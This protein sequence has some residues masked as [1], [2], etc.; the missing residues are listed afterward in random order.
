MDNLANVSHRAQAAGMGAVC[1]LDHFASGG[2][3]TPHNLY[4]AGYLATGASLMAE[5]GSDDEVWL[6]YLADAARE[7]ALCLSLEERRGLREP[8]V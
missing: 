5:P 3:V 4:Q 8:T 7:L 1:D 6:R 2:K